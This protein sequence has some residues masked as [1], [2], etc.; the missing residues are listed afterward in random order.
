MLFYAGMILGILGL[1]CSAAAQTDTELRP[2][3][4]AVWPQKEK[5]QEYKVVEFN[6][7]EANGCEISK[8]FDGDWQTFWAS[9]DDKVEPGPKSV[10]LDLGGEKEVLGFVYLPPPYR[11]KGRIGK[12]NFYVGNDR[13]KWGEPAAKGMCK[14][15]VSTF[16]PDVNEQFETVLLPE[17]VKGRYVKLMSVSDIENDPDVAI[18]EFIVITDYNQ[19]PYKGTT[20]A[21][22]KGQRMAPSIHLNYG[23]PPARLAYL[24]MTPE[25]ST[26]GSY[27]M[28]AGFNGG[29]YGLQ[30]QSNGRK[31]LLFSLWDSA[32][33]DNPAMVHGD[34]QVKVLYED[35]E[36]RVRRFGGEGVGVQSF[37]DYDW[38]VGHKYKF[39]VKVDHFLIP[40]WTAYTAYFFMEERGEWRKLM[41][42]AAK[43]K[44][45]PLTGVHSFVEDFKRDFSSFNFPRCASFT[46]IWALDNH[47]KWVQCSEAYFSADGNPNRNVNAGPRP[48]GA[49][50]VTGGNATDSNN[51]LWHKFK[52]GQGKKLP[53][54][55][56]E[57][58][59]EKALPDDARLEDV[60]DEE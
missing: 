22:L 28:A 27:F 48:E 41:T 1:A 55:L 58:V 31:V 44:E 20:L 14:R 38:K 7:G 32:N 40:E 5:P 6:G 56:P 43:Q 16:W 59:L 25:A 37:L 9:S 52:V 50:M 45:R 24:E 17:P 11:A 4:P 30:E 26:A 29:Y 42:L 8:A 54:V 23:L 13:Q 35:P 21:Q 51:H 10:T 19:Y 39:V 57:F 49:F 15:Y 46:Q 53:P 12:Y 34:E 36:M 2:A 47:E 60:E 3:T 33:T 18:A